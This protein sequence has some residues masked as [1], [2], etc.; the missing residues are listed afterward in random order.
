[1]DRPS[2]VTGRWEII[3]DGWAPTPLNR[4]L[5]HWA[6][7]ARL[8]RYDRDHVVLFGGMAHVPLPTRKRRV[9]LRITLPPKQRRWDGDALWKSLLD[10]CTKAQLIKDDNPNW[11][12][13]GTV[14]YEKERGEL[15]TTIIIEELDDNPDRMP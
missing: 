9:S 8:K 10:A 3:I 13:L 12:Q 1:M 15:S 7:A 2:V 4:L 14:E 6:A 11:C 5:G